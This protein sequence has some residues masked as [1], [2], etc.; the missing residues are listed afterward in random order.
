M[1]IL[2]STTAGG[3]GIGMRLAAIAGALLLIPVLSACGNG[4]GGGLY[5]SGER[6]ADATAV[7]AQE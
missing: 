1:S 6:A 4:E 3:S 7:T 5:G 2:T